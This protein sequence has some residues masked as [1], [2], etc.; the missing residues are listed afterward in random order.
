MSDDLGR[1]AFVKR[2]AMTFLAVVAAPSALTGCG[3]GGADCTHTATADEEAARTAAHYVDNA[4]NPRREC[5]ICN[6][7]TSAGEGQC[8]PCSLN[9][10]RV[11]PLGVCDRFAERA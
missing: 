10:G 8:G 6:F 2:G 5:D 4:H 3:G 1:R 7:F 9:M 11:N